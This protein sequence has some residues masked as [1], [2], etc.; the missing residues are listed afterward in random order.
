LDFPE[1][2]VSQEIMEILVRPVVQD[3]RANKDHVVKLVLQDNPALE[4]MMER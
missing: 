3:L 1:H 2:Q 4:A